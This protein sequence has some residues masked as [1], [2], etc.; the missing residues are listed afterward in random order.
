MLLSPAFWER[1]DYVLAEIPEKVIG[2]WDIVSPILGYAGIEFLRPGQEVE[3]SWGLEKL[4]E[5]NRGSGVVSG[6][7][8]REKVD[9]MV[10]LEENMFQGESMGKWGIYRMIRDRARV[11]TGG[12]WVGPRMEP[13][14]WILRRVKELLL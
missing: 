14:I 2:K 6:E 8:V 5:A 1:F 7:E 3:E 12:W 13:K 9:H 4:Y 11:F 10:G